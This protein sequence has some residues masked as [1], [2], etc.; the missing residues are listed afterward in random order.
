MKL[1]WA[2][3]APSHS[4]SVAAEAAAT[5]DRSAGYS[6]QYEA[7]VQQRVHTW[8]QMP[9]CCKDM[10]AWQQKQPR[11]QMQ[12]QQGR[13]INRLLLLLCPSCEHGCCLGMESP[14][15]HSINRP[16]APYTKGAPLFQL[17]L[18]I[19][20]AGLV[21]R[22]PFPLFMPLAVHTATCGIY[23]TRDSARCCKHTEL[24]RLTSQYACTLGCC[25]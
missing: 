25:C 17:S 8:L 24:Q 6:W 9:Y 4:S 2:A 10:Y 20:L 11:D 19:W 3:G 13:S 7:D 12:L 22:C 16:R 18:L 21:V 15:Q 14:R 5:P 1:R 23:Q